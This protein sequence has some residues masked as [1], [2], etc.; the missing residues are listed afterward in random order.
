MKYAVVIEKAEESYGAYV[1]DLPRCIA[2][3]ETVD[4]VKKLIQEAIEFHIEGLKE[5][6]EPVPE[7]ASSVE[8]IEV[9]A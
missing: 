9:A 7:P 3:G 4:E 6:G 5:S 8:F 1:P 2:A